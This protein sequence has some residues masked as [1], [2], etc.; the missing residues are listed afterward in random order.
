MTKQELVRT[1]MIKAMKDKNK[2]RKDTLSMLLAALKNAEIDKRRELTEAEENAIVQK[3]IKQTKETLETV[4]ANRTDIINECTYRIE[5]LSEFAPQMMSADEILQVINETIEELKISIP[6]K[7]KDKG[8]IMK[9][10]MPKVKGK[11]D[12]KLVNQLLGEILV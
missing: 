11:A 8:N 5:V 4:P 12:G 2:A 6:V 10:L 1:E 3:E 7:K 9:S